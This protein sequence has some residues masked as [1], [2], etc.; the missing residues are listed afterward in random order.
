MVRT[1]SSQ[2]FPMKRGRAVEPGPELAD[3]RTELLATFDVL[4][5]RTQ[6]SGTL[7]DDVNA[8]DLVLMLN[9]IP[10]RLPDAAD[11]GPMADLADRYTG[12]LLDGL[13]TPGT[14]ALTLPAPGRREIDQFFR[15]THDL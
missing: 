2:L 11:G 4:V 15:A 9:M 3:V 6:E 5:V 8:V 7:R 14:E 13:R 10:A 12:V 1:R